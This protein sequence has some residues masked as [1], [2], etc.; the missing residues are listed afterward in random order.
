[1]KELDRNETADKELEE[2]GRTGEVMVTTPPITKE[3]EQ[4]A[5]THTDK[6]TDSSTEKPSAPTEESQKQASLLIEEDLDKRKDL[7]EETPNTFPSL[8]D[9]GEKHPVLETEVSLFLSR[10]TS[11]YEEGDIWR[12]MNFFSVSAIENNS[13][14]YADIRTFYASNFEG[15]RYNYTLENVRIEKR[16]DSIIVRGNYSI[17]KITDDDKTPRAQGIIQWTLTREEGILKIL[18]TDYEKM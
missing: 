6:V 16:E 1:M 11:A 12:F 2:L 18:R 17:K 15:N 7:A 13:L 14:H 9:T 8:E 5:Q 4:I 10:Y 3:E